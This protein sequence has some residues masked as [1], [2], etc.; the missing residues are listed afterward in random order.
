MNRFLTLVFLLPVVVSAQSFQYANL[1]TQAAPIQFGT[2]AMATS[3]SANLL[4]IKPQTDGETLPVIN[5][6]SIALWGE[7]AAKYQTFTVGQTGLIWLKD[8]QLPAKDSVLT[9]LLANYKPVRSGVN[10]IVNLPNGKDGRF[11]LREEAQTSSG[12]T[13]RLSTT[14]LS[15]AYFSQLPAT[16]ANGAGIT[17]Q[18]T[19]QESLIGSGSVPWLTAAAPQKD[20][21]AVLVLNTS[22]NLLSKNINGTIAIDIP[23]GNSF[24]FATSAEGGVIGWRSPAGT[25]I[26]FT[27]DNI[28]MGGQLTVAGSI[29]TPGLCIADEHATLNISPNG[30]LWGSDHSIAFIGTGAALSNDGVGFTSLLIQSRNSGGITLDVINDF[31]SGLGYIQFSVNSH[32]VGRFTTD[33][34]QLRNLHDDEIRSIRNPKRGLQVYS[35]DRLAPVTYNG[36]QWTYCACDQSL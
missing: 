33:G 6:A 3:L 15:A 23:D 27:A 12:V 16:A 28:N 2:Q 24:Q 10:D 22:A 4:S 32:E 26:A 18:A 36:K 11:E 30:F 31:S 19:Y 14:L 34:F 9:A 13:A 17:L 25:Q 20:K 35:I 7:K 1:V 21:G 8:P 29:N 5:G